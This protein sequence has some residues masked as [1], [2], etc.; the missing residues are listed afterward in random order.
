MNAIFTI[1]TVLIIIA[2]I[3]LILV[4]LLQNGKGEGM[5]S[6]FVAGNQTFGVRQ[7]ADILEKIT[8]GLVA[9]ILVLSVISSFTTGTNGA[10][11]DVTDKIE[12]VAEEAQPA[13]PTAPVQA[14]IPAETTSENN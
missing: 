3:L 13:F 1:L 4:V 2:A 6:N 5:A 9:F 11:M 12:N 14:E 10:E 8:W 7:T